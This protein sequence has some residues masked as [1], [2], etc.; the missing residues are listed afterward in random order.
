MAFATVSFAQTG[1]VGINTPTPNANAALDIVS[2]NKGL[3]PPRVALTATNSPAPLASNVAGMVVYNTAT[4]GTAPNNVVPGLYYNNGTIWVP[5]TDTAPATSVLNTSAG[6]N[7]STTVNG[8]TGTAVPMVNSISNTFTPATALLSTTVNG[9]AGTTVDL[10]SLKVEPW[11]NQATNTQATANTQ[12]IYQMGN[13]GINTTA[14]SSSLDVKGANNQPATTGTTT[15]ATIRMEGSSNHVLDMGTFA[16]APYGSYLQSTE[17]GNLATILP[18]SFN[19]NGGNVGI[20][21]ATP[22]EALDVGLGNLRVRNINTNTGTAADRLVV[23]DATGVFKTV[24]APSNAVTSVSN[25]SAGNNLSTTVNGITGA[26]V[27]MI[28]SNAL[29]ATNGNLVSTVNG[30][31]STPAVPVLIAASNGL[32]ATNGDVKLGGTLSQPTNIVASAANTLSINGL[33]PSTGKIATIVTD[34]GGTIRYQDGSSVSA[35][36]LNG[37]VITTNAEN[38]IFFYLNKTATPNEDLDNLNEFSGSTFTAKRAGLYAVNIHF[39][40]DQHPST[41]DGGDGYLAAVRVT[42]GPAGSTTIYSAQG[43]LKVGINEAG[44]GFAPIALQRNDLIK[45]AAG[46][47]IEIQTLTYGA[48]TSVTGYYEVSIYRVD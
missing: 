40:Y 27:P 36:R 41:V 5:T 31:A 15:N 1:N 19:P 12:N 7:L 32:T 26:A 16:T 28:N 14:P 17:K 30:V 4:A 33:Q 38:N 21:N 48:T 13:V 35:V 44:G 25:T 3:L 18:L 22:T 43:Y 29:S 34:A 8:I 39:R 10:S 9:V 45:L 23:A 42:K 6:N 2:T 46:E 11:S 20:N 47:V 37:N 24:A